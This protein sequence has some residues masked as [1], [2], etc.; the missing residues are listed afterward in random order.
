MPVYGKSLAFSAT[1]VRLIIDAYGPAATITR[2]ILPFEQI[3]FRCHEYPFIGARLVCFF[4][5]R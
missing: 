1:T 4:C 3:D 5:T 2:V